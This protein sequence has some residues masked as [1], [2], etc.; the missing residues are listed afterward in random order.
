M[1]FCLV[2]VHMLS[3]AFLV[4]TS[5]R[6]KVTGEPIDLLMKQLHVRLH[7]IVASTF[8]GT[9]WMITGDDR[10]FFVNGF[11]V[12]P[13]V[14]ISVA[15]EDAST[16]LTRESPDLLMDCHHV[17]LDLGSFPRFVA[18]SQSWTGMLRCRVSLEVFGQIAF[19]G[20][21]VATAFFLALEPL[22]DCVNGSHVL[23]E[24]AL[25]FAFVVTVRP[26][27]AMFLTTLLC[28]THLTL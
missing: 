20:R 4:P 28:R 14:A 11:Q 1:A 15:R 13:Q 7:A 8:E 27:T 23:V 3:H 24:V 9:A 5:V 25:P 12:M 10:S 19:S 17:F 6:A 22:D 21:F 16:V 18:A 2:S 26:W